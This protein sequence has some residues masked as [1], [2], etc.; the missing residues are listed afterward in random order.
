LL[1]DLETTTPGHRRQGGLPLPIAR[2]EIR[3]FGNEKLGDSFTS[4]EMKRLLA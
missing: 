2:S 3:P 1:N 4:G